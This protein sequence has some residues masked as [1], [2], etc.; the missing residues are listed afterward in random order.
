MVDLVALDEMWVKK[1]ED[2]EKLYKNANRDVKGI[3]CIADLLFE[4]N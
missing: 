4:N 1:R 2:K 3:E